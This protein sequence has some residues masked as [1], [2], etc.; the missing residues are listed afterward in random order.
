MNILLIRHASYLPK[1][2]DPNEGLSSKGISE[3][4]LSAKGLQRLGEK[5]DYI[6]SSPKLRAKQTAEILASTHNVANIQ[7]ADELLPSSTPE[8][9]ISLLLQTYQKNAAYVSHLPFLEI[10]IKSLTGKN[11][12]FEP[13]TVVSIDLD[14]E[15]P[16]SSN[17]NWVKSPNDFKNLL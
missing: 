8:L 6:F 7:K 4:K 10:L 11:V 15:S 1:S 17:L 5:V 12:S 13:G 14:L 3:A 9:F 2:A 16:P